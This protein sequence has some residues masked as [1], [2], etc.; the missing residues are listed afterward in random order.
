[1]DDKQKYFCSYSGRLTNFL[2]AFGL[3]YIDKQENPV[4]GYYFCVFERTQKLVD[5][6]EFWSE[7]KNRFNNYDDKGNK[8]EKAGEK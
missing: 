8:K 3:N 2:K 5:I 6:V 7:C 1:M 4:T